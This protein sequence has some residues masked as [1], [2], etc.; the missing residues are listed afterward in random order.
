MLGSEPYFINEVQCH[1]SLPYFHLFGFPIFS[2]LIS[3]F[4]YTLLQPPSCL[5]LLPVLLTLQRKLEYSQHQKA[6][7]G[8]VPICLSRF[9]KYEW[10][11]V[12]LHKSTET[13]L[14][15]QLSSK[16]CCQAAV[17]NSDFH[18]MKCL[19]GSNYRD[20]RR[21]YVFRASQY[22]NGFLCSIQITL[23]FFHLFN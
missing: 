19:N 4:I 17:S 15:K 12:S 21:H 23:R 22:I 13:L 7:R 10:Q 11:M 16:L 5:V 3:D 2:I 14:L 1:S 9:H 6:G 8:P 20:T 18:D